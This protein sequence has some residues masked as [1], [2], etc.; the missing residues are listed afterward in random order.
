VLI[1][2]IVSNIAVVA[3][4]SFEIVLNPNHAH[5][6]HRSH[7][8]DVALDAR[9]WRSRMWAFESVAESFEAV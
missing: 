8:Y 7:R 1:V 6:H 9:G 3:A 5:R 2:D 4:V